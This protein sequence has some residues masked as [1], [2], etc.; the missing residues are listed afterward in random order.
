[1]GTISIFSLEF[2]GLRFAC[3]RDFTGAY[4][5]QAGDFTVTMPP[6]GAGALAEGGGRIRMRAQVASQLRREM[7]AGA[8]FRR[9]ML[10]VDGRTAHV[11]LGV[12]DA[13]DSVYIE[14]GTAR[15][16]LTDAQAAVLLAVL[17]QLGR[18]V[19]ALYRATDGPDDMRMGV[20]P[21]LR[22]PGLDL[23]RW[24]DDSQW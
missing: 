18:D 6:D 17:D 14:I 10:A 3:S 12:S 21:G 7:K 9:D 1:M 15:M 4:S 8:T 5:L 11:E 22:G 16:A 20:A 23:P 13:G 2:S 19:T 24:A